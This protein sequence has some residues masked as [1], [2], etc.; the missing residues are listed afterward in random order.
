MCIR[1]SKGAVGGF[2]RQTGG[3]TR[4]F[5]TLNE[6]MCERALAGTINAFNGDQQTLVEHNGRQSI[7]PEQVDV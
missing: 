3:K 7:S 1:D 2:T 5:E 6:M 4:G